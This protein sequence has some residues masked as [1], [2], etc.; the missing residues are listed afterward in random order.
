MIRTSYSHFLTLPH[1]GIA[2]DE[3][4]TAHPSMQATTWPIFKAFFT[5]RFRQHHNKQSTLQDAGIANS[6]TTDDYNTIQNQL[7]GVQADNATRDSQFA[8]IVQQ[9]SQ[10][11]HTLAHSA[12]SNATRP[13]VPE[14]TFFDHLMS[15]P[16]SPT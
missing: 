16:F 5:Q 9:L 7:A 13:P 1:M 10:Q 14:L 12:S 11:L 4:E 15:S 8:Q 6:A 2:C 3:W